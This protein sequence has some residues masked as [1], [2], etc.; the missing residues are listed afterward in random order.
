MIF[1]MKS[2]QFCTHAFNG[3]FQVIKA[4]WIALHLIDVNNK[5][6]L[7]RRFHRP[8]L[9]P[10]LRLRLDLY[11]PA[12]FSILDKESFNL[13]VRLKTRLAGVKSGSRQK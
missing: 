5:Y 13:R 4:A 6:F 1:E 11:A 10:A 2:N 9:T 7:L 12:F 3:N 8:H